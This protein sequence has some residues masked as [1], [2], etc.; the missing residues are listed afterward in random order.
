M[1]NKA[2]LIAEIGVNHSGDL[3]KAMRLVD[4]ACEAQC[5]GVK[6]QYRS[7]SSDFFSKQDEMGSTMIKDELSRSNNQLNWLKEI[8]TYTKSRGI[9]IGFSFFKV[10][11]LLQFLSEDYYMDFI[12]IPSA[13]FTNSALI[14]EAKK[15]AIPVMLSTGGLDE[16]TISKYL[17]KYNL[18][19]EDV[20][21]HCISN[22]PTSLG[23]QQMDFLKRLPN[24]GSYQIGYSSHDENWEVNLIALTY[25]VKVIERH[26]CLDKG[27]D[28]LDISS[29]SDKKELI[30]LN[31]FVE[32][33]SSILNCEVR[34]PN[35]GEIMNV[36][37]LGVGL[38]YSRDL[39]EGDIVTND[40][41]RE[42]SPATGIRPAESSKV[43][44]KKVLS[45]IKADTPV[46]L[47][48]FMHFERISKS[49]VLYDFIENNRLSIP[50]RLHD[51]GIIRSRFQTSFFEL[52]LSYKEVYQLESGFDSLL[53]FITK[54][55][56]FS[57]HL[58][59][60]ISKDE[61]IN[62]HST[63]QNIR[64][65]SNRII[66]ICLELAE[67]LQDV[68]GNK[69]YVLGSFSQRELLTKEEFYQVHS[70][71]IRDIESDRNI[72]ILSQWL[73]VKAWY[74]GGSWTLDLFC[75]FEDIGLVR[76]YNLPICL[77]IAH[78][79]LSANYFSQNWYD[80]WSKLKPFTR[81][82]HLSD[83]VGIDGEGVAFGKGDIHSFQDLM[84]NDHIK[85][86]EVW[87]GHLENG[88]GFYE[89]LEFLHEIR[90][91]S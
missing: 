58:P 12:K 60:Y 51:I 49:H 75:E 37:N 78:L 26:I 24:Y 88:K 86:L 90:Y 42:L 31:Q 63:N 71:F 74:F 1:T 59:D 38:Y 67:S 70:D 19:N 82:I 77:D 23:N 7:S 56:H 16:E 43:L 8:I 22:Y 18:S 64:I 61:L 4:M 29:S 40:D 10:D 44:G 50:V 52:H 65:E 48:H 72:T 84:Q 87:E 45:D 6:F 28:G 39:S 89:A 20:V 83:A 55:D 47:S 53:E 32:N 34:L 46:K 62:P 91:E 3:S 11:D 9:A 13:E 14:A 76:K 66:E 57:I 15:L 30:S 27:E 17:G 33:F 2:R 25:G 41:L 5:Y 85:V 79:I 69:V 68:T 36:R 21:F 54:G 73:P 35:Q 80:W 81:H